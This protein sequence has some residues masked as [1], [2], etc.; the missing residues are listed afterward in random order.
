MKD[1][2][3]CK[4][5]SHRPNILG[6]ITECMLRVKWLSTYWPNEPCEIFEAKVVAPVVASRP[7][8]SGN[9]PDNGDETARK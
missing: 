6:G 5:Y 7:G 9:D 2:D 4:H 3:Q 8:K 1:C